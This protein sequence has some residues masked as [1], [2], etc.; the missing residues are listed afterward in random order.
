MKNAGICPR[1]FLACG[2]CIEAKKHGKAFER[3]KICFRLFPAF[4]TG[5]Q[6]RKTAVLLTWAPANLTVAGA[7]YF[8]GRIPEKER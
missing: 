6:P 7:F 3:L 4:S 8:W 1:F 2:C 5:Q